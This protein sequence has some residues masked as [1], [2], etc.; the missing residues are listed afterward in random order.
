MA[1]F[2]GM[3]NFDKPG[4]GVDKDAPEKRGFFLFFDI[5]FRKFWRIST[6]SLF[7][8]LFSLPAVV[9]F[10]LLN[11]FLQTW[12]SPIK[13]PDFISSIGVILTIFLICFLGAGPASAG[14]AYV[15]RNFTREEH[16]WPW[17][18]FWSQIKAN[19]WQG[20]GVFLLD[21][22][23][24]TVLP[25]A[26]SLYFQYGSQMPISPLFSAV[27]GFLAIIFLFIWILM[28]FFLYPM[29]VT[30]D[31]RFGKL[32][33]TAFLLTMAKLPQCILIF[34]LSMAVFALFLALYLVNVGLMVLYAALGFSF[35]TFVYVFYATRV[36]DEILEK[37]Q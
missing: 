2:F 13:D 16:A 28:H 17:E 27:F 3:F 26:A 19:F 5:L 23:L 20:M 1:G 34:I 10:F 14:Q 21:I 30:L 36:M 25:G 32:I 8:T 15:L 12:I 6:L 7:Y 22:V 29:M 18:D 31:M 35:V 37:E 4:R 11:T 9:V 33:K 24:L